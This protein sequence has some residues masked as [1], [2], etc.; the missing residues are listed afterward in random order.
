MPDLEEPLTYWKSAF[1]RQKARDDKILIPE[2]GIEPDFDDSLGRMEEIKDQLNELL[3]KKK[4]E[5]K[6]RTLKFTDVGKEIYQMETPKSVKVPSSW[7]QMSATKDV[8]R[9][10]FPQLT[11]LV[12]ELQEAEELHSQLVREIASRLFKKFDVDYNTWL[13]AIKIVAQLDCLVSLAKSSNSLGEPCCRPQFLDEER[14]FVDFEELRHPCMLNTVDDFIPNDIKLGGTQAKIN[15]LT[16]A[17]AAGKSTV[18][19]MVSFS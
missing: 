1:D 15:L 17:N 2:R 13:L 3:S 16:G 11:D 19:R 7:R 14:S 6:C 4:G 10:Y 12:R 18:L 5:L 9:W 8:K